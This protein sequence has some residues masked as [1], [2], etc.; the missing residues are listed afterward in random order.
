MISIIHD[1]SNRANQACS[2]KPEI[3][4]ASQG[5][6][7][8]ESKS[9]RPPHRDMTRTMEESALQ[10]TNETMLHIHQRIINE[11]NSHGS[12]TVSELIILRSMIRTRT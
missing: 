4:I 7:C 8:N 9:Y 2:P 11:F 6:N 5:Q 1:D 3:G 12:F 10:I